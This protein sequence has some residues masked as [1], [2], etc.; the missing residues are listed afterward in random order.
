MLE[1]ITPQIMQILI[2][3]ACVG[4]INWALSAYDKDYNLVS[5]IV[6]DGE[7]QKYLYYAIGL[8]GLLALVKTLQPMM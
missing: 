2:I 4:A 1:F 5:M 3:V 6:K 7:Q 8:A